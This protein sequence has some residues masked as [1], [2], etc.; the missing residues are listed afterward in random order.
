MG[1]I[2]LNRME[3]LFWGRAALERGKTIGFVRPTVA[4]NQWINDQHQCPK[5]EY[6]HPQ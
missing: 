4:G 6:R 1:A 3:L 5:R 2:V